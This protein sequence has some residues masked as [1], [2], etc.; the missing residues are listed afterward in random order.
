MPTLTF[1]AT[2]EVAKQLETIIARQSARLG[3]TVSR[4]DVLVPHIK[5][6]YRDELGENGI[7]EQEDQEIKR[8]AINL[9]STSVQ[10]L[11]SSLHHYNNDDIEIVRHAHLLAHKRGEKTKKKILYS[12]L[13]KLIGSMPKGSKNP[14]GDLTGLIKADAATPNE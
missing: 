3:F 10:D 12:K 13:R 6:M 5:N 7:V 2:D 14:V 4:G 9:I 8:R 11:Q 1:Y